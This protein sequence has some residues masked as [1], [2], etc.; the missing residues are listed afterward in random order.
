M[1]FI[2][3]LVSQDCNTTQGLFP[4]YI[5]QSRELEKASCYPNLLMVFRATR[6]CARL[7]NGIFLRAACCS[8]SRLSTDREARAQQLRDVEGTGPLRDQRCTD[9]AIS[10]TFVPPAKEI[11]KST[12][13]PTEVIPNPEY[14]T[15][16]TKDQQVLN[17]LL[18]SLSREIMSQVTTTTTAAATWAAI[19]GMFAAQ[20]RARMINTCMTL[21]TA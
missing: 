1:L 16:F 20:S 11:P 12:D 10:P 6:F 13:K 18:S 8:L 19:E 3:L 14:A 2:S 7:R 21:A 15:W 17:Y 5:T 9:G 4:A